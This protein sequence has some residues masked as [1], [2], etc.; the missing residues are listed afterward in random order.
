MYGGKYIRN[1]KKSQLLKESSASSIKDNNKY[2]YNLHIPSPAIEEKTFKNNNNYTSTIENNEKKETIKKLRNNKTN[3]N[4]F[5][6]SKTLTTFQAL[7]KTDEKSKEKEIENLK[8]I[9]KDKYKEKEE[10]NQN[11]NNSNI[12]QSIQIKRRINFRER[13][14]NSRKKRAFFNNNTNDNN[15]NNNNNKNN[16]ENLEKEKT[17]RN[18]YKEGKIRKNENL[19][20]KMEYSKEI[21]R[22]KKFEILKKN[23]D[24]EVIKDDFENEKENEKDSI[25]NER[26]IKGENIGNEIKDTVKCKMCSQKIVH[27]KMCPK[28]QNISCEKCLYNWFLKDQNKECIFCKE[29]INFYEYISVPF[30][31]TIVDFVEKIIFDRKK[32]SSSFQNSYDSKTNNIIN[33]ENSIINNSNQINDNC[34]IHQ[35]EKIYYFC[36]NCNKGYCKTCFVFFGKEKD[37]HLNH[38]IIEYA[39]Y[40]KINLPLLKQEEEEIDK[41]INYINNLIDQNNSYKGLYKFEQKTL[42]DYIS[43]IQKEYNKKMDDIIQNIDNQ[44]SKLKQSL[45]NY[46]KSK[47]EIDDFYKKIV[48]KSRNMPNAQYLIDKL[49]KINQEKIPFQVSFKEPGNI[50]FKVYKSEKEELNF[51]N[52]CQTKKIIFEDNLEMTIENNLNNYININLNIPKDNSNNHFYKAIIYYKIKESNKVYGYL[53]NEL[54]QGNN[55]YSM[56]KKIQIDENDFYIFEIKSIIYDFYLE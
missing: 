47:K 26:D 16:F 53:L 41:K 35:N 54:K 9:E 56:G 12:N 4:I 6:I 33:E 36:L 30:M 51:D 10:N 34:E 50:N 49:S 31:D 43:F 48:V 38:K 46:Q 11:V 1:L 37:K 25:S 29:P 7:S 22:K 42:N 3:N 55:Y 17:F 20:K 21:K 2:R 8:D 39:N 13:L 18:T 23:I 45:E 40:K 28:C 24:R 19:E 44:I 27:P 15:N 32:Y 5:N 52:K 14:N